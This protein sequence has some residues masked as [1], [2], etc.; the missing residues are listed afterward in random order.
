MPRPRFGTFVA[1]VCIQSSRR[2]SRELHVPALPG[3]DILVVVAVQHG[4]C[5]RWHCIDCFA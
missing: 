2:Q 5:L 1:A 3:L 4:K